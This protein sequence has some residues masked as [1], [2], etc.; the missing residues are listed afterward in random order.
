MYGQPGRDWTADDVPSGPYFHGSRRAYEPGE[1]LLTDVVNNLQGEE[2]DRRMCFATT[3]REQALDWA[4]QRGIR[5][6][7]DNLYVYEVEMIEPEVDVNMH[8][9]EASDSITSVMSRCGRVI[10]LVQVLPKSGYPN[11]FWD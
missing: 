10:R 6:G 9:P 7:G 3:S 4:Y 1:C 5:H 11:A 8:R 2:D